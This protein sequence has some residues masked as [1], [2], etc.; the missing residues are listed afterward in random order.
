[1]F[2]MSLSER[3][4]CLMRNGNGKVFCFVRKFF[5]Y[6]QLSELN[7]AVCQSR[8]CLW[9]SKN[10]GFKMLESCTDPQTMAHEPRTRHNLGSLK[11]LGTGG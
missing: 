1:M 10:N 3:A 4:L 11:L 6:L 5:S 2:E 9:S 8:V 7:S